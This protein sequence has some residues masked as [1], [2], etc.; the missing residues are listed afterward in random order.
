MSLHLP[1]ESATA[2]DSLQQH[3]PPFVIEL[4]WSDI[5]EYIVD[6]H[7]SR[8]VVLYGRF[9]HFGYTISMRSV[10]DTTVESLLN[11]RIPRT[12]TD[13]LYDGQ[14]TGCKSIN[15]TAW[16]NPLTFIPFLQSSSKGIIRSTRGNNK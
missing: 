7:V 12:G 11:S 3:L 5:Q 13:P 8:T 9:G 2:L 15:E 14:A 4:G 6:G 1:F 10:E 16:S